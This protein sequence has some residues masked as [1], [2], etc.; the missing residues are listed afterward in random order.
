MLIEPF[1]GGGIISLTAVFEHLANNVVMAEIDD[2]VAAVWQTIVD[3]DAPWLAKRILDFDLNPD[4]VAYE[5]SLQYTT[6]RDMA[7]QTILKNRTFHGGILAKGA[8]LLKKGENGKG[9]A[10]RWYPGTLARR[11]MDIHEIS[12]HIDFHQA[13][14]LELIRKYSASK[15]ACFFIDPPYTAGG[16]KAGKRLYRFC[17][18]D[19]ELLFSLC[20]SIKGDFLITY[21]NSD[22]VRNMAQKHGFDMKLIPMKNTHHAEMKELVIGKD[23]SWME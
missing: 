4:S 13:D 1:V 2:E 11:L 14:G 7:F 19:H 23:L 21:D 5:L 12:S 18:I 10:S 6:V 9:I 16:K 20:K 8:G 3:G 22:E 17:D 15:N